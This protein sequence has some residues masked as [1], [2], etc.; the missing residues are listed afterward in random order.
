[1]WPSVWF[2]GCKHLLGI[3]P[4]AHLF[5]FGRQ[6]CHLCHGH[7]IIHSITIPALKADAFLTTAGSW[8]QWLWGGGLPGAVHHGAQAVGNE[9]H[10]ALGEPALQSGL[11][12]ELRPRVHGGR[13]LVQDED[14]GFPE[15]GAGQTQQLL[16]AQAGREGNSQARCSCVCTS[17]C[18]GHAPKGVS[19]QP[20]EWRVP[21]PQSW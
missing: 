11:H 18:A 7:L 4:W 16:L 9:Q 3:C 17:G 8:G 1:M 19:Q 10:R 13:G 21:R 6:S 5:P 14:L 12:L 20:Q 2:S 15:K